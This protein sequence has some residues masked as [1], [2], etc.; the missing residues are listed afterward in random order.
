QAFDSAVATA[1]EPDFEPAL[2]SVIL[3]S[4]GAI[5]DTNSQSIGYQAYLF[6]DKGETVINNTDF[7]QAPVVE[8]ITIT[9]MPR[10]QILY[11]SKI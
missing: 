7:E 3:P 1:P 11:Q 8:D 4:G 6:S 10:T 2:S 9:Y 5:P